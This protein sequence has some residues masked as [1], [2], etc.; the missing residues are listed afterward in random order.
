MIIHIEIMIKSGRGRGRTDQPGILAI[1]PGVRPAVVSPSGLRHRPR[2]PSRPHPTAYRVDAV[3]GAGPSSGA[4]DVLAHPADVAGRAGVEAPGVPAAP[5]R[6]AD[7]VIG[8]P[9]EP[10]VLKAPEEGRVV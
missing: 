2:S 9:V 8:Q 5:D 1:H 6:R 7:L 4:R 3:R 10:A